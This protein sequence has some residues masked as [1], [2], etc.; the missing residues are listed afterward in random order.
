M[1]VIALS[2]LAC[3]LLGCAAKTISLSHHVALAS[4]S[5]PKQRKVSVPVALSNRQP[6]K[7]AHASREDAIAL[8]RR[9][10]ILHG[11]TQVLS[12]D[13]GK[14]T[15]E[16]LII[17]KHPEGMISHWSVDAAAKDYS[18]GTCKH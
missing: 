11:N 16:W 13:L 2:L 6:A 9:E 4:T 10:G 14:S 1:K 15:R 7:K 17:L 8:L 5:P 12:A 18:G 3:A